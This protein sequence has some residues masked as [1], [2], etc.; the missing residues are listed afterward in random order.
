MNKQS[1]FSTNFGDQIYQLLKE[2][3]PENPKAKE[4]L[5]KWEILVKSKDYDPNCS[6]VRAFNRNR[7]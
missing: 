5:E 3:A 2:L 4:L 7:D 6:M 1:C